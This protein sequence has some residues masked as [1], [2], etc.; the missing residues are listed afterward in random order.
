MK[1]ITVAISLPDNGGITFFGPLSAAMASK[2]PS[3]VGQQRLYLCANHD[4]LEV[5]K[6]LLAMLAD[7]QMSDAPLKPGTAPE[8]IEPSF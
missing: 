1:R 6:T 2:S 3:S 4:P 7:L 8:E 5:G